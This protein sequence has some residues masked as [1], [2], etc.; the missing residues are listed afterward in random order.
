MLLKSYS[1]REGPQEESSKKLVKQVGDQ[2]AGT[3]KQRS[4]AMLTTWGSN[5]HDLGPV[6]LGRLRTWGPS[7]AWDLGPATVGMLRTCGPATLMTWGSDPWNAHDL[8]PSDTHDLG[9]RPLG[10]SGPVAQ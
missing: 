4:A 9:Q 5:A 8:G 3:S 1:V 7:D 10:C 6:T 2:T